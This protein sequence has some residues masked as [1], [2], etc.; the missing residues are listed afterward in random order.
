MAPLSPPPGSSTTWAPEPGREDAVALSAVTTWTC[1]AGNG[2]RHGGDRVEGEGVRQVGASDARWRVQPA[3]GP[4][5]EPLTG[6]TIRHVGFVRCTH[7]DDRLRPGAP[8]STPA[9]RAAKMTGIRMSRHA[10]GPQ[11]RRKGRQRVRRIRPDRQLPWSYRFV[12]TLLRLVM[13]PLTRRDWRG[14]EHLPRTGGFVVSPNHLSYADPI[15]F[16]HFLY[17][18]GHP[19]FFLAKDERLPHPGRSAGCSRTPSRSPSTAAPARRPRRFRAAVDA[20]REGKCVADLPRGH[21]HPR[22]ATCGR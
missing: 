7:L 10:A 2:L 1:A 13:Q 11:P 22:P 3:L 12:A 16:A 19:P 18:N 21:A 17:D 14:A 4:G 6:T 8:A 5:R 20:V 15:A 9:R